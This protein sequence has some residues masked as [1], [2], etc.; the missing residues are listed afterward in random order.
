MKITLGPGTFKRPLVGKLG[1]VVKTFPVFRPGLFTAMSGQDCHFSDGDVRT[2]AAVFSPATRPAPL[3]LGHPT[4]DRPV[5]GQVK[6]LTCKEGKLY[7]TA[8]FSEE[9][10]G[11]VRQGCYRYVSASF[12]S[13][14]EMRN[15]RRGAYYLR[16]VGFL[17]AVPPAVKGLG[18]VTFCESDFAWVGG[19][20]VDVAFSEG[21]RA[22]VAAPKDERFGVTVDPERRVIHAV[23]QEM[24]K[25]NPGMSYAA[26]AHK[27]MAVL[28]GRWH[29]RTASF[30]E[31]SPRRHQYLGDADPGRLAFHEAVLDYQAASGSDD[32]QESAQRLLSFNLGLI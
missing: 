21:V 6:G 11:L 19:A 20:M 30:S 5:Y 24:V 9:L 15:P 32:Y 14:Q 8:E 12:F 31:P 29:E 13:P 27:A 22:A 17:G 7:A 2:M 1:K 23:I 18:P 25:R 4:D 28:D 26:A 10:H 3:C 16:H